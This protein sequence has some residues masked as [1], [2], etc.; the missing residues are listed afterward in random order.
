M[1]YY[2][3]GNLGALGNYVQ[4]SSI[5]RRPAVNMILADTAATPLALLN[6]ITSSSLDSSSFSSSSRTNVNIVN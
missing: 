6:L 5:D 1:F 3:L 2:A 4:G